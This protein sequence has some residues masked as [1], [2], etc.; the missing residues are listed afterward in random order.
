MVRESPNGAVLIE[1]QTVVNAEPARNGRWIL[2]YDVINVQSKLIHR[3]LHT[4]FLNWFIFFFSTVTTFSNRRFTRYCLL[5]PFHVMS[6][7]KQIKFQT[8]SMVNCYYWPNIEHGNIKI[9]HL[10]SVF[11]CFRTYLKLYTY[12]YKGHGPRIIF[13]TSKFKRNPR[14]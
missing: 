4:V 10:L 6:P 5:L 9:I 3:F 8:A 13:I 2:I 7:S 12:F 11:C 1:R 14:K